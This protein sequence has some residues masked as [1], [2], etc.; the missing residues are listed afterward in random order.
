MCTVPAGDCGVPRAADV[1]VVGAGAAGAVVAAR[2]SE[3]GS[4]DVL[5]VEA[6]P[7]YRSAD[8]PAAVRGTDIGRALAMRSLRWPGLLAR[9]TEHQPPRAYACGRGAGGSSAINGQLA[10]R[11]TPAD[12]D[13]WVRAGCAGW[14]WPAVQPAFVRL[15]RDMD[16]GG[17]PGHGSRG[18]VPISRVPADRRGPVST[19]L[20]TA[21][22]GLGHPEHRDLNA[23]GST[24]ISP[25]A[26]H[27]R[28]GMRVSSN[29]SHLE[30]ARSRP[31][32]RVAGRH[33]VSRVLFSAGRVR[34]VEL[35]AEGHREVVSA[36]AV[37]LC[38]GAVY[39]PAILLRSGVGPADRLGA[40]GI[41][42]VA[43]LPGVGAGL[44]D[45]P[46]VML[47][48]RLTE[49][50]AAR[51]LETDSGCCLLRAGRADDI[52]VLPLDRT[53][54][55]ASG[56]LMVSLMRPESTGSVRLRSRDPA[57]DPSLDLRLL[58]DRG[59]LDRLR[60]AVLHAAELLDHPAF[61]EVVEGRQARPDGALDQWLRENCRTLYHPSGTCRM[62]PAGE[63]GT[64]V[65][66]EGRVLGVDGLWVADASVMP[67]PCGVPPYLTTVMVAERLAAAI[68][69]GLLRAR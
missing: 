46:A 56:G 2:L 68:R 14:S 20:Y 52:Q 28:D 34:G 9:L 39:S 38:A 40:L 27:R 18:P 10:V 7:D 13:A 51:S 63:G 61:R 48:F 32:L 6:G 49:A 23:E 5:L 66:E 24:G 22:V 55:P 17:H 44:S 65:D 4:A 30:P 19:A 33:L 45:H 64:V 43:P 54:G 59:D 67:V 57:D 29:D 69:N 26:W 36:P 41:E 58:S 12:F 53:V 60:D 62:G 35:A 1:V 11:G 21:A 16:F 37:V 50:A 25:A 42:I 31:R 8:A 47:G 3:A 15:E